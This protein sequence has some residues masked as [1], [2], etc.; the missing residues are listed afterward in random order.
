MFCPSCAGEASGLVNRQ[1]ITM[2][3][4]EAPDVLELGD[5]RQLTLGHDGPLDDNCL[6]SMRPVESDG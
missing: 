3:N 4:Y 5:A 2:K 6:C 1:V